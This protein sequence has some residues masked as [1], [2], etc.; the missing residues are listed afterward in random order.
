MKK[1][2]IDESSLI[3]ASVPINE[4]CDF[5]T[6]INIFLNKKRVQNK[7]LNRLL[8]KLKENEDVEPPQ[9]DLS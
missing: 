2:P 3:P 1:E 5:E 6:N 4:S 8:D 9:H 7:V